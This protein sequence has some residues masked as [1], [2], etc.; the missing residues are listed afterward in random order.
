MLRFNSSWAFTQKAF[1]D[2]RDQVMERFQENWSIKPTRVT[3]Q[4]QGFLQAKVNRTL[5]R[6][7]QATT[8]L[9]RDRFQLNSGD[10]VFQLG[11]DRPQ[12]EGKS[13]RLSRNPAKAILQVTARLANQLTDPI[14]RQAQEPSEE[15]QLIRYRFVLS[16]FVKNVLQGQPEA[17]PPGV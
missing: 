11:N 8:S 7:P 16:Q 6:L 2:Y 9:P 12:L 14:I 17:T 5:D 15:S 4:N 10:W 1:G 3:P 13:A